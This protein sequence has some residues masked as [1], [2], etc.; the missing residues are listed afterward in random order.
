[1]LRLAHQLI[2]FLWLF[3]LIL[4][5]VT[6]L[7]LKQS[8]SLGWFACILRR[9]GRSLVTQIKRY[10]DKKVSR[11]PMWLTAISNTTLSKLAK[12]WSLSLGFTSL[13]LS[14]I[15]TFSFESAFVLWL[16]LLLSTAAVV[17]WL[18]NSD[19]FSSA[20][21]YFLAQEV[22]TWSILFS[23]I[24]TSDWGSCLGRCK[25]WFVL[26]SYLILLKLA[27]HIWFVKFI[28]LGN[29]DGWVIGYGVL[30]PFLW[31][32]FFLPSP[33]PLLLVMCGVVVS[34]SFNYIPTQWYGVIGLFGIL[35]VFY[36]VTTHLVVTLLV[37]LVILVSWL[38][39]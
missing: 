20:L 22:L 6:R 10:P 29:A 5:H 27:F 9:L 12:Y 11:P 8:C 33:L 4:K 30:I 13:L 37:V 18:V 32:M 25:C 14:L 2:L 34:C 7:L 19:H 36:L 35:S 1:V 26:F 23:L 21:N 31:L 3:Q 28:L 24:Y 17:A 39:S 15:L 16:G 38:A